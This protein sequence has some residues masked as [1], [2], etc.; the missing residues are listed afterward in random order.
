M[1]TF[2]WNII[3]KAPLIKTLYCTIPLLFLLYTYDQMDNRVL[4]F[5]LSM[6]CVLAHSSTVQSLLFGHT[7]YQLEELKHP[8][9]NSASG[10]I[11]TFCS[12]TDFNSREIAAVYKIACCTPIAKVNWLNK[13][14][15]ELRLYSYI[16][17][18]NKRAM[19]HHHF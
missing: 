6:G 7:D 14:S 4:P 11:E 10:Y 16:P 3:S 2:Q 8:V 17:R 13:T 19:P 15:M 12:T 9:V 18:R 1:L 5:P